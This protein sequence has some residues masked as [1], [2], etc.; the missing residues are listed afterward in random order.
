MFCYVVGIISTI[1]I[2]PIFVLTFNRAAI[3]GFWKG[4]ATA[5]GSSVADGILF[6]LSLAGF[7]TFIGRSTFLHLTLDLLGGL[8]LLG[9]GIYYFIKHIVTLDTVKITVKEGVLAIFIKAFL[10]TLFSPGA[11]LYFGY[12]SIQVSELFSDIGR[13]TGMLGV[14]MVSFGTLTSFSILSFVSSR[15]GATLAGKKL[16]N[17]SKMTG[18]LLMLG[19]IY[20]LYDFCVALGYF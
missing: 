1:G 18:I 12:M 16:K 15:M 19:A 13:F 10:V 17:I 2:G 5:I 11:I 20:F 3:Y 14:L 6:A 9:L 8:F 4:F 7:L